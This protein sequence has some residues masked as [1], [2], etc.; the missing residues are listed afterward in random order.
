MTAEELIEILKTFPPETRIFT[1]GYEGGYQNAGK[2]HNVRKFALHW[3]DEEEWYFGPHQLCED[4][5]DIADAEER[6]LLI[7][8]GI[9][10]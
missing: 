1:S 7:V 2:P 8:D 9:C 5:S 3:Y 10:I 6:K 4:A